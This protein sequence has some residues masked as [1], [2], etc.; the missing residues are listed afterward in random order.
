MLKPIYFP[1]TTISKPVFDAIKTGFRQTI[2]YQPADLTVPENLQKWS[3]NNQL[4]L[5]IPVKGDEEKL[6]AILKAY[7]EWAKL[8]YE[9]Q[10]LKQAFIRAVRNTSPFFDET[11]ASQIKADIKGKTRGDGL[12]KRPDWLFDSRV[13]LA[14]AQEFD[15]QNEALRN[16]FDLLGKMEN[17]LVKNFQDQSGQVSDFA[18]KTMENMLPTDDSA[19]YMIPERMKA[20]AR[21]VMSDQHLHQELMPGLFITNSR[22]VISY[23]LDSSS[24]AEQVFRFE[25]IPVIEKPHPMLESWQDSLMDTLNR[26]ASTPWPYQLKKI[27]HPPPDK[28]ANR[29]VSLNFYIMPG[30]MPSGFI[31]RYGEYEY[32][33]VE[34]QGNMNIHLLKRKTRIR[35]LKIF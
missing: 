31:A 26:L 32:P 5:R 25:S 17:D 2:V 10:G 28:I 3:E 29:T 1:F 4:Q 20:W 12:S 30:E 9:K 34:A 11:S 7:K 13:F 27:S 35:D 19:D 23:L 14:M 33:S 22:A 15:Q 24:H 21:L 16:D 8:H 18:R 6:A